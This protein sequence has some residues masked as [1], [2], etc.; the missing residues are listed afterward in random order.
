M[1]DLN[2]VNLSLEWPEVRTNKL[3]LKLFICLLGLPA[4]F[5][6]LASPSDAV[7]LTIQDKTAY[8]RAFKAASKSGWNL[9]NRHVRGVQQTLPKKALQ[10]MRIIDPK[11]KSSF[12]EI[13]NFIKANPHWPQQA[14]LRQRAEEA[15][16]YK[17]TEAEMLDWLQNQQP[18]TGSGAYHIVRVLLDKKRVSEATEV[19]RRAW[20]NVDMTY[21]IEQKFRKKYRN[22]IRAEDHIER[23]DRLLWTRRISA[24]RRQFRRMTQDYQQLGLARIALMRREPGVDYLVSKVPKRLISD[25]GLIYERVRW[26][27]KNRLY[28]SAID[29]LYQADKPRWS[30]K[31]WWIERRIL[32][33]WLLRKGRV[34]DAY[35]LA[36]TH[37]QT[38]GIGLAEG[39]WLSGWI[40]LR[41]LHRYI[42]AFK[43]FKKMFDNVSYPVSKA[44]AAYW[45]GRA[46]EASGNTEISLQWFAAA[47]SHVTSF[48]GQLA[49]AKLPPSA[50]PHFPPE[51]KPTK[52]ETKTFAQY[53]LVRLVKMLS[54]M[55]LK[56]EI[57]PFVKH[58]ART[59]NTDGEW[60]LLASLAR[61]EIRDDL[62]IHVAKKALRQGVVLSQLGYP[63]LRWTLKNKP[64]PAFVKAVVRQ[65]SVFDPKAM[66]RAGA[67]GLMQLMPKTAYRVARRLNIRYS[68]AR[69]TRDPKFN[70]TIG[71]AYLLQLLEDFQGSPILALAAYNAGPARAKRW[72]KNFGDP[73]RSIEDAV[74]WIESIPFYETRNYVQ[75]VLENFT[76]YRARG[77]NKKITLLPKATSTLP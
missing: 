29:L 32:T 51:P 35:R 7:T 16:N 40:A 46:A 55:N 73:E 13:I 26:R 36:S 69:L 6:M 61:D 77:T 49:T 44:R 41:S 52:S 58:L 62:A 39:E 54:A 37:R 50:R 74:D 22:L 30:A 4:A 8:K 71:S 48:Y 47:A 53:E 15:I 70:L 38:D 64:D 43:H 42:D 67:R 9:A 31:K 11:G 20:I 75:R 18:N 3:L 57:D 14:K 27:R 59:T 76:V 65:E 23:L 24:A 33:R 2:W 12:K 45:A 72:Q 1:S 10:W 63:D 19:A 25:P 68:R 60:S 21:R 17:T 34:K 5:I 28:D 66:S 56:N